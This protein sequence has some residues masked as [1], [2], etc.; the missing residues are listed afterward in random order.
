MSTSSA[1]VTQS[2]SSTQ[3]SAA[4]SSMPSSSS[5]SPIM[6]TDDSTSWSQSSATLQAY[7]SIESSQTSPVSSQLSSGVIRYQTNLEGE[8]VPISIAASSSSAG[9]IVG[10]IIQSDPAAIANNISVAV[11]ASTNQF[12]PELKKIK[13]THYQIDSKLNM[14]GGD[15]SQLNLDSNRS[16]LIPQ[17][18]LEERIGGILCCTVCLD[19]PQTAIYQVRSLTFILIRYFQ[20]LSY[21]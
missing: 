11:Q 3:L 4:S 10:T 15:P 17:R 7:N 18:K 13:L 12:E 16:L 8:L 20:T 6:N 14:I 1:A 2:A 21:S 19:L 9:G 5:S